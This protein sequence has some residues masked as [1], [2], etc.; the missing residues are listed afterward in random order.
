MCN[1]AFFRKTEKGERKYLELT[2]DYYIIDCALK[3]LI[4]HRP[5]RGDWT[6]E[7]YEKIETQFEKGFIYIKVVS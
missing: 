3:K 4:F 7:S 6:E 1:I 2:T 5:W